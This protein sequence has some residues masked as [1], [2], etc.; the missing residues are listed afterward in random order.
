MRL[1]CALLLLATVFLPGCGGCR[2]T[3]IP[4]KRP[5]PQTPLPDFQVDRL[6]T[7]P[8]SITRVESAI[9]PG[10]WTAATLEVVANNFDFQGE[11]RTDPVALV[12][13]PF[14][15]RFSRP[16]LLPKKQKKY[17]ELLLFAPGGAPQRQIGIRLLGRHGG[18]EIVTSSFPATLLPDHQF[19]L[20]V[21]AREPD[22][23]TYLRGLNSVVPVSQGMIDD[24][25]RA[26]YRVMAPK[27]KSR[28]PLSDNAL[29]WTS[30]AYILWDGLDPSLL[31]PRQ[32]Q[33]M[34]DWLHWGGQ[35]IVSG[36]ETLDLLRGSFLDRYLP[37]EGGATWNLNDTQ[38]IELNRKWSLHE[39]IHVTTRRGWVAQVLSPRPHGRTL[40]HTPEDQPLMIEGDI[41]RGRIL[42]SA[43]RLSER[44]LLGWK[45]LDGFVNGC[46]LRR[47]A[48]HFQMD[49]EG[50]QQIRWA[51]EVNRAGQG[52][53]YFEPRKICNLRFFTRDTGTPSR[54][55]TRAPVA[56]AGEW[57]VVLSGGDVAAWNDASGTAN[58]ATAALKSA[59]SVVIPG[60]DFVVRVLAVYLVALVPINWAL[61][62]AMGRVEWAWLAVPVI[63]VGFALAIVRL[64]QLD[65]GFVRARTEIGV[66]ELYGG[67]PRAHVTRYTALYTSLS[68]E[69]E[70]AFD[71]PTALA[72][73]FPAGR[74][75]LFGQGRDTIELV[76]D[77][78]VR[79]RGFQVASNSLGMLHSEHMMELPGSIRLEPDAGGRVQV[80]ND[81]SLALRDTVVLN[82][83]DA[84]WLGALDPGGRATLAPIKDATLQRARSLFAERRT[85]SKVTSPEAAD[86]S[87]PLETLVALAEGQLDEREWR[88]VAWTQDELLGMNVSPAS[89]QLRCANLVVVHLRYEPPNDP[90]PDVNVAFETKKESQAE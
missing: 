62:R 61:F 54:P 50:L 10:H 58:R 85:A 38:L 64:A 56:D 87:I 42:V 35:L 43:F 27:I 79:L 31:T 17:L 30:I 34:L 40:V 1:V 8:H 48:R 4:R 18:R 69:Y 57:D 28:V 25:T 44:T 3:P 73:P 36:P 33:A 2:G 5:K 90:Q 6:L 22:L 78:Q 47:P 68:T 20:F 39:V 67:Y 77:R 82:P 46:L 81:T 11:L 72:Q 52:A 12:D 26:H 51:Q 49:A 37:A 14:E 70:L 74:K 89:S 19:Y 83:R 75:P 71:D 55:G 60:S 41:G 21:L 45:G 16:A 7:L 13:V 80:V 24:V 59:S 32:Q 76:R 23:Y 53:D 66:V 88:L 65:I 86:E 15:L 63:S 29:T 9:K 84:A